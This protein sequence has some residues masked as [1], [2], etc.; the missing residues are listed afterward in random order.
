M[1]KLAFIVVVLATAGLSSCGNAPKASFSN[2]IDSLSYMAGIANTQGL[3]MYYEQQLGMDS[4]VYADFVRGIE[5]GLSKTTK[6]DEAYMTGLQVGQSVGSRVF[7]MM[8][9]RLFGN[10]SVNKLNKTNL[11]A[12]FVDAVKHRVKVSA[13]SANIYY[14]TK[15]K[16]IKA[17]INSVKYADNKARNVGMR[18]QE[19]NLNYKAGKNTYIYAGNLNVKG[20]SAAS[21]ISD[22]RVQVGVKYVAPAGDKTNWWVG[23]AVGDDLW[24]A[25]IGGSYALAPNVDWDLSYQYTDVINVDDV[26]GVK[27]RGL[28]TGLTFKL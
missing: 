28:Y 14:E 2:E 24:R 6:K 13:D 19:F 22:N 23:G 3:D 10:D 17:R 15:S 11:L 12:G 21:G 9:D 4:T 27:T 8:N 18:M 16:A 25:E 20:T 5:A 1:K 26:A 7:E